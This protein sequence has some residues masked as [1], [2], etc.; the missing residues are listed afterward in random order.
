[1]VVAARVVAAVTAVVGVTVAVAVAAAL[2]VTIVVVTEDLPLKAAV[3]PAGITAGD[4]RAYSHFAATEKIGS[5]AAVATV[6]AVAV[7]EMMVN[8]GKTLLALASTIV[9]GT[10]S[11]AS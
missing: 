5:S 3:E 4:L 11:S 10:K 2:A 1:M 6:S 8:Q 7:D 9:A